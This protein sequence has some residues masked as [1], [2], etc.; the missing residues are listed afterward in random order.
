MAKPSK[1]PTWATVEDTDPTTG[2][3]NRVEPSAG[4]KQTGFTYNEKP[5]RQYFNWLLWLIGEWLTWINDNINQALNTNSDVVFDSVQATTQ[6]TSPTINSDI[7]NTKALN[8]LSSG[9]GEV[10]TDLLNSS[11]SITTPLLNITGSDSKAKRY[12]E[13]VFGRKWAPTLADNTG[14][15]GFPIDSTSLLLSRNLATPNNL[16]SDFKIAHAG[17]YK[18]SFEV[19]I[20]PS[21]SYTSQLQIRI[22]NTPFTYKEIA[23]SSTEKSS[24]CIST[25]AY[26]NVND[27]VTIFMSNSV[28]GVSATD[29]PSFLIEMIGE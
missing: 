8:A 22:N 10:N 6:T 19:S 18:I 4:I 24:N 1:I 5:P 7:V 20:V 12:S 25:I 13:G 29:G 14:T 3:L 15:I 9:N 2:K 16:H 17:Y 28:L 27:V 26:L 23:G 11:V 21:G